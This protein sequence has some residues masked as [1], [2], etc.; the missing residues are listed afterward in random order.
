VPTGK[1]IYCFGGILIWL[2]E[3]PSKMWPHDSSHSLNRFALMQPNI[4]FPCLV[5]HKLI[6]DWLPSTF[7]PIPKLALINRKPCML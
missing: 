7:N 3:K 2:N 1:K 6:N 5:V 4:R